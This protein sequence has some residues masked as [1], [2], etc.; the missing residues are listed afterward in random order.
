VATS[1]HST[2]SMR[3]LAAPFGIE[4][5]A[6]FRQP[7]TPGESAQLRA[8]LWRHQIVVARGQSIHPEQH[9]ELVRGIGT[10]LG[11][12][13][14]IGYV[15]NVRADGGLGNTEIA[16]HSDLAFTTDPYRAISL[17]A[18]DVVDDASSTVYASSAWAW[19]HLPAE[20]RARI[21][22]L[23]VRHVYG[24]NYQSRNRLSTIDAGDPWTIHPLVWTH[25]ETG[26]PILYVHRNQTDRIMELDEQASE[27]LIGALFEVAYQPE[28]RYEHRWRRGDIVIWDNLALQHARGDVSGVGNR[29]LH[30]A[31][32]ADRSYFDLCPMK[33][34]EAEKE[35]A[36][37]YSTPASEHGQAAGR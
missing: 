37:R 26:T 18:V 25:P 15:S 33:T 22:G 7:L 8:L 35:H 29:T 23:S 9:V 34:E 32:V 2:W 6:D 16:F 1:V 13:D 12:P 19:E 4:I 3:R 31:V 10:V 28:N 24:A 20:L 21:D 17:Y 11:T 5:D 14:T 27:E 36:R 30:R